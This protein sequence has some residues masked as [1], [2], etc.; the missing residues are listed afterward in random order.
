MADY[1]PVAAALPATLPPIT[2]EQSIRL[3]R[4]LIRAF[5]HDKPITR[6][7]ARATTKGRACWISRTARTSDHVTRG[8]AR[9][10]HD[11]SHEIFRSIYPSRRPHD[12]LHVRYEADM[13]AWV[14]QRLD[15][16]TAPPKVK[17]R[18]TTA[19]KRS[20]ALARTEAA[21]KRWESKERR[22]KNALRKLRARQ[23][24]QARKISVDTGF[25]SKSADASRCDGRNR[26]NL[27]GGRHAR[28]SLHSESVDAAAC[29]G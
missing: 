17:P 29:V 26:R 24:Q 9:V 21:I 4:A 5:R 14:A 13:A 15:R 22:A 25:A 8:V 7:L 11:V 1:T 20:E 12:P 2:R 16:F 23:R 3:C 27:H 6:W 18:P 10:I 19:Q 28:T